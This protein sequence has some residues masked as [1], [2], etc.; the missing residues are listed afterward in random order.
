MA[1]S[2]YNLAGVNV[3]LGQYDAAVSQYLKA[4]E[5]HRAAGDKVGIALNSYGVGTLYATQGKYG[6]ALSALQ[7]A[8]NDYE[9]AKDQTWENAEA[10]ASYGKTLSEV[11]R[12]DEGR[13]YLDNAVKLATDVKND[14]IL[15]EALNYQGDSF[16]YAGDFSSARQQ[17]EKAMQMATRAKYREVITR[18]KF[19][20]ARLDVVQNRAAGAIPS[21]KKLVEE[22]D[23]V[24]L[25]ALSV[26][27]SLYLAKA[28]LETGKPQDAQQELDRAMNRAEKLGLLIEQAQAHFLLAEVYEKTGK[29]REYAP[30]YQEAVRLLESIS[31]EQGAGRL[32]DRS[33]LKD[34]YQQSV[35]S[36][37]GSA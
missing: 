17:Y 10:M 31:K 33:D 32:L 1:E 13:K 19:D 36:Y 26:Q 29:S 18:S 15:A 34:L 16:F 22:T 7:E 5:I 25:R 2:L 3:D 35:K 30:Q 27:A 6:S 21:L 14:G 37:Q 12:W 24:G 20:L 11:G 28:L 23:T 4:L 9:Q 8:V